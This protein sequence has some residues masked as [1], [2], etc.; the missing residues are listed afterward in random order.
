MKKLIKILSILLLSNYLTLASSDSY[1]NARK[2]TA[3]TRSKQ[4][5]RTT[6]HDEAVSEV[7]PLFI[8]DFRF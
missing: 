1:S 4:H 3:L 6:K 5:N 2:L 8:F 7:H